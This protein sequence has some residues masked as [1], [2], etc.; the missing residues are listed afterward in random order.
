MLRKL[1]RAKR[2]RKRRVRLP[3]NA[4]ALL[5]N[6]AVLQKLLVKRKRKRAVLKLKHAGRRLKLS[7]RRKK[8][9]NVVRNVRL[10][11]HVRLRRAKKRAQLSVR[12]RRLLKHNVLVWL[13]K[14]QIA[15]QA[16]RTAPQQLPMR[17]MFHEVMRN[18]RAVLLP[19]KDVCQC[20]LRATTRFLVILV[21]TT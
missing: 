15:L 17:T 2:L 9:G 6:A 8:R 20:R 11:K 1:K 19:T 13:L 14:K 3:Q 4:N 12:K 16:K 10:E 5:R 21:L 7:E 18:S